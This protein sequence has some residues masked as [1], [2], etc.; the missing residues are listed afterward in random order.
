MYYIYYLILL[1]LLN[2]KWAAAV[3]CFAI[4]GHGFESLDSN[5]S[6]LFHKNVVPR[7]QTPK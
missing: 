1:I 5:F 4:P 3:C 2:T 6:I 7:I